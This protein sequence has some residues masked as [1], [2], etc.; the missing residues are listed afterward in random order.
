MHLIQRRS[1][2]VNDYREA[3]TCFFP[4]FLD[5]KVMT[6]IMSVAVTEEAVAEVHSRTYYFLQL[7]QSFLAMSLAKD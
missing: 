3:G 2:F 4:N 6:T 5:I 1:I 7:D